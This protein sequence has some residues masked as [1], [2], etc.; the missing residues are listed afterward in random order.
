MGREMQPEYYD[1][2]FEEGHGFDLHYKD[3]YYWVHWTQV[4]KF[5]GR[6]LDKKILEVGCGT[7]QLAEYLY[8]EGY[9]NYNGFDFS[10]KGV[11]LSK[12]R[13]PAYNFYV[14]DATDQ[15][16]FNVEYDTAI[17]LE[18]LEHVVDDIKII[19][20]IQ[21]G[22]EVI[23]SVPDFPAPSHVRRF[24][25]E[26]D[27]KKRYFRYI[28]I[29]SIV[30]IGSIFVAV[31]IRSDFK[32]SFMQRILSTREK[33]GLGSIYNRIKHRWKNFTYRFFQT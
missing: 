12:K 5:L 15:K 3:G 1:N 14:G 4:I 27:L 2:Y 33:I 21:V 28:D 25:R 23:F 6:N 30:K 24:L 22:K 31:G 17:C 7:G 29:K 19:K 8:D 11:E 16:N 9:R 10:T 18:I 20:N 32:P 26:Y 13:V